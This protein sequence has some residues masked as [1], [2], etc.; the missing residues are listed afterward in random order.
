MM[1][2]RDLRIVFMGTPDFA[3]PSLEML[4]REGYRVEAVI[5]QPDRMSGR[6]HKTLP[7][8]VKEFAIEHG[9][10]VFQ[11]E[12][13]LKRGSGN[14]TR[15]ESQ[16]SHYGSVWADYFSGDIGYSRIRMH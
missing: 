1:M 3:I 12:E 4:L 15:G 2:K 10:Q 7:P 6:G 13:A 11:F 5:T 14:D 16:S 8:P 9:I